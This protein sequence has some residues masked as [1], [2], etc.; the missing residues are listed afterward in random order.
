QARDE[1]FP[2][3]IALLGRR[4]RDALLAI[5]GVARLIDD[6]GDEASGDREALLDWVECDLDRAYSGEDPEHPAMNALAVA[7]W[8]HGLPAGPFHRLVQANRRDQTV[9][10]YETFGDLLSYCDL[11]AAPVGEL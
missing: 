3:A 7:V 6:I 9:A 4:R 8:A 2:V 11:S 10:R 1:N 5:Y